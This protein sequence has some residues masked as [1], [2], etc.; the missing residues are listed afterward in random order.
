MGDPYRPATSQISNFPF[1]SRTSPQSAPLFHSTA[2]EFR[3]EE[4]ETE[5]NREIADF[6]ALQ[7]S[8]RHF[9]GSYL[10]DSSELDLDGQD[11]NVDEQQTPFCDDKF[12]KGKGIRSSWRGSEASYEEPGFIEREGMKA[13]V[14]RTEGY[15]SRSNCGAGGNLVDVGLED[16]LQDVRRS[17]SSGAGDD[18][19]PSIQQL[20]E[21]PQ[22]RS[23]R[24]R[25]GSLPVPVEIDPQSRPQNPHSPCV[26]DS[27]SLGSIRGEAVAH[28]SFWG[29]LFL[30]SLAGLLATA[31]LV[32]L[33]TSAPSGDKSRWGDTVYM[34]VHGSFLLLGIY[35][36][37]SIFVS[38]I[39][40]VVLRS[41]VRPLVYVAIIA[42]PVI[43]FSFSLYPF[44]SSFKGTW[45]GTSIQDKVMRY[46]SVIPVIIASL[47]VYNVIQGR[48]AVGKAISILEFACRILAAN[49][50][51]LAFGIGT[52]ICIVIWTWT[53]VL[54]FTRVFLGGHLS[55]LRFFTID[56][57]SWLLG[58]YFILIYI[59]SLGIIAGIQRAVTAATV[60]QWYFHRFATQAPTSRQIV[61]AA[62]VHSLTTLFG[63]I[64][65]SRLLAL[66]IR[67]PLIL[68]PRRLV[69]VLTLFAYSLVPTPIAA[70]TNPLALTYAAIY[71]QPLT[72]SARGLT[73]M[74]LL[75][76][77]AAKSSLH[78]RWF[79]WSYGDTPSLLSYRLSKLILHAAR[80]MMSLALGFGGWVTS[81]RTLSTTGTGGATRGSLYAY[82]VGLIAGT[83]GWSVLGS[84]EGVVADIVDASVIC[85]SSE[86]GTYGMEARYCREAGLLF[87]EGPRPPK[88]GDLQTTNV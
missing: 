55:G 27:S 30:I 36:L 57:S 58:V 3:E 13:A 51:L 45:H 32:Y 60:S 71:S 59:W 86:I 39:W 76:P 82:V 67:L 37:V 24:A 16:T 26:S 23:S 77:S 17:G 35:T 29:R 53:W 44:V 79:S 21:P 5:H 22:P 73:Q 9:D 25:L 6:Y 40:I 52:L 78:P 46:G 72:V 43:L 42:V 65:L 7:K 47:W 20:R 69:Y 61:H 54:M 66:L 83:I 28:D 18:D 68:L 56:V 34:T 2:E 75:S 64:C 48:H 8:R 19:P 62:T 14:G 87:G 81:A 80:F 70:L 74:T 4:E 63:T 50:E 49:V 12:T 33:H 85:W 84:M 15:A 11:S 1:V 31:F 88:P 10:R 41:Y 38:L